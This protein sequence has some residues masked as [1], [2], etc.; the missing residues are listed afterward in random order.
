MNLV[1]AS[2]GPDAAAREIGLYFSRD[3]ILSHQPALT[4]W[5]RAPDEA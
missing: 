4:A 1:H 3:E 5:F 2:D